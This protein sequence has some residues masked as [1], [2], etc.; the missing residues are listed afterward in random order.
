MA[1]INGDLVK[2]KSKGKKFSKELWS[3]MSPEAIV[4]TL[5]KTQPC[6]TGYSK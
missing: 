2:S 6:K 5:P 4:K 3:A 1:Q